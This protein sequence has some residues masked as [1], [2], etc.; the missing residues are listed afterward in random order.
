MRKLKQTLMVLVCVLLVAGTI[1]LATAEDT[2]PEGYKAIY[3]LNDLQA[4]GE[5]LSGNYILMADL[6]GKAEEFTPIGTSSDPFTGTLDGNGHTIRNLTI[7]ADDHAGLFAYTKSATIQN[8]TLEKCTIEAAGDEAGGF[9]AQANQKLTLENCHLINTDVSG[10]NYVGGLVGYSNG[11]TSTT[12]VTTQWVTW[13]SITG[14]TVTASGIYVG[15]IMGGTQSTVNS[16]VIYIKE[17]FCAANLVETAQGGAGGLVGGCSVKLDISDCY[18]T[19]DVQCTASSATSKTLYGAAGG[20]LGYTTFKTGSTNTS[21]IGTCYNTGNVTGVSYASGMVAYESTGMTV[22]DCF[23]AGTIYGKSMGPYHGGNVGSTLRCGTLTSWK[24]GATGTTL[25]EPSSLLGTSAST[26]S[27]ETL[28]SWMEKGLKGGGIVL[29]TTYWDYSKGGYPLL[30]NNLQPE[31][32]SQ[33]TYTVTYAQKLASNMTGMT[34]PEAV[35]L[36]ENEDF[37]PST[38]TYDSEWVYVFLYWEDEAHNRYDPASAQP[39]QVTGDVTLTP[40]WKLYSINGDGVWNIDDALTI[41]QYVQDPD[42]SA[43]VPEQEV[44][45]D[46]NHDGKINIDDALAVMQEIAN[47]VLK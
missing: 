44:Y 47:G 35:E 41:M 46:Y 17:T 11:T 2:V 15:G 14:G 13:C 31:L 22:S 12:E 21:A 4:V 32:A 29:T 16:R 18:N 43:I 20:I 3:D 19:A 23:N 7:R 26:D 38:P 10:V 1:P 37:L 8:L 9:I 5:N 36:A 34:V 33:Q 40:V 24:N 28:L 39:Y 6:D 42:H 25:V 27:A 30:K 45:L